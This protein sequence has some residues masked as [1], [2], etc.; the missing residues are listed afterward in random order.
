MTFPSTLSLFLHQLRQ[1]KSRAFKAPFYALSGLI[2]HPKP[3]RLAR[4]IMTAAKSSNIPL[5]EEFE[6]LRIGEK[7]F[8]S[9]YPVYNP[10]D[11]F[12][13]HIANSVASIVG[14]EAA[15]VFSSLQRPRTLDKGDLILPIPALR[16]KGGKPQDLVEK[17]IQQV[18]LFA[19]VRKATL[20]T[21]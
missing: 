6:R 8:S 13:I 21:Y 4:N 19:E 1:P 10:L 16:V 5:E 15:L 12:K 18:Y 9:C 3:T 2:L 14:V 17:V 11:G 7:K 20:N